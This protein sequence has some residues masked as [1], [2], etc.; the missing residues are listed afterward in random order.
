LKCGDRRGAAA[1]LGKHAEQLSGEVARVL[2]GVKAACD[3][4][5]I[6]ALLAGNTACRERGLQRD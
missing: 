4:P 3:R 6:P 2:S 1:Q 5:A